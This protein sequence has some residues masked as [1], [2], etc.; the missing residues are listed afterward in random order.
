MKLQ[1]DR[2][3]IEPMMQA[4]PRLEEFRDQLRFGNRVEVPFKR[5]EPAELD[6]LQALYGEGDRELRA[7]AAQIATS[8]GIPV[9]LARAGTDFCNHC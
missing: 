7:Q 5:F 1:I 2:R 3:H 8:A 4:F 9:V 6:M